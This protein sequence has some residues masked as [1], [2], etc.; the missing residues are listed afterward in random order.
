[1]LFILQN[2]PMKSNLLFTFLMVLL[3]AGTAFALNS[4]DAV[5]EQQLD[6]IAQ[7]KDSGISWEE[8]CAVNTVPAMPMQPMVFEKAPFN[9]KPHTFSLS[10]EVFY[11]HYSESQKQRT[12]TGPWYGLRGSYTYRPARG[13]ILNTPL[14]NYYSLDLFH[15][16]GKNEMR[17]NKDRFDSSIKKSVFKNIRAEMYEARFLVG[18]DLM[19]SQTV[20]FTPYTGFAVRYKTEHAGG[21]RN[22]LDDGA[23]LLGQDRSNIYYYLPLGVTMDMAPNKDYEIS[24]NLE[25]DHLIKGKARHRYADMDQ[26]TMA[27]DL[28]SQ[29]LHFDQNR[30]Y[31]LRGSVKLLRH[32]SAADLFMEPFARYWHID[33]SKLD[34]GDLASTTIYRTENKNRTLEVG[35]KFGVQ[36]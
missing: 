8:V 22:D 29:N 10:P 9:A 24:F 27:F 3:H 35:S 14:F 4:R 2:M 1:M 30:G 31:G 13:S 33:A 23:I 7:H 6:C 16:R 20:R 18:R 28:A 32:Y 26:Y 12:L 11:Y 21:Y 5:I 36:F 25:Y 17:I 34:S 19:A 15:A